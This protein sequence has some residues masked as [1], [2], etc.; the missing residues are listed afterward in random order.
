MDAASTLVVSYCFPP[1]SD[2]AGIVAA[3]RVREAGV[4]VDVICNA[5]DAIRKRDASLTRIGGDLVR[6]F[7]AVPSRT[8]FSSDRSVRDF[9]T[10]GLARV[11]AWESVQGPYEKL[12]SRAQFIHSHFLAARYKAARPD[13][14]WTAEF[15]DPLSHDVMGHTRTSPFGA[16][17]LM[18]HLSNGITA[19]GFTPP[20]SDNINEW[21]EVAAFALADHFLFTNALQRDFMVDHCHDRSLAGRVL[22]RAT[23]S[24]HPTLPREFY[25]LVESE[26]PPAD[27]VNVAYFGNFYANRGVDLI[28]DALAA[29][30]REQ[31]A[32][33]MLHVFTASP[34]SLVPAVERAGLGHCVRVGPYVD[35][36]EFLALS[37][38][39]DLLLV[40]DA[41]APEG[42]VNPFLPSK[43]SD[44]A[45]ST[46]PVWAVVQEG[47]SLDAL[48]AF[49]FR[50]P[51][52]H[53]SGL[54]QVL[55]QLALGGAPARRVTTPG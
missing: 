6:R 29:L 52:E 17:F 45:G 35:Y 42:V 28:L 14:E 11:D 24:P 50:T 25:S 48:D 53:L 38:R 9:V 49:A 40:N 37:D 51:V 41:V 31:S 15:S 19:A 12:Y 21:C 26:T 22:D 44:Y 20:E 55:S 32:R 5:M 10:A 18:D 23:V 30:P 36:L 7:A 4:P 16:G 8:A 13:V 1:Y 2:T 34:D 47:S 43:W 33:L 54:T 3:K 27:R 39:M 46:T